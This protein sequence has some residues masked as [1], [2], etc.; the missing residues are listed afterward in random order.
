MIPKHH[1]D[2]WIKLISNCNPAISTK[3]NGYRKQGRQAKSHYVWQFH[4]TPFKHSSPSVEPVDDVLEKSQVHVALW[5]L[6]GSDSFDISLGEAP[7]GL[8]AL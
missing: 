8:H 4:D 6:T 1:E 5:A 3:Q 2:R 7:S